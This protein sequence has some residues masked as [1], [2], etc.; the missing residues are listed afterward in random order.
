MGTKVLTL[1]DK[2][3]A[4]ARGMNSLLVLIDEG[5]FGP[6]DAQK[7]LGKAYSAGLREGLKQ[8]KATD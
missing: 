1:T 7:E 5:N 2:Q 4:I 3:K 8:A 6:E